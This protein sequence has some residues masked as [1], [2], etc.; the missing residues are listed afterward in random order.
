M[1]PASWISAQNLLAQ[2][3]GIALLAVQ[4][5][6]LGPR[7][8][9]LMA[10]VM[11]FIG[12]CDTVLQVAATDALISVREIEDEHYA[13]IMTVSAALATA[14]GIGVLIFAR[15]IALFFD[16]P[17]LEAMLRWM[18]LLPL[19]SVLASAPSAASRR[20]LNFRP[21][22]IRELAGMIV[23]GIFGMA[24]ALLHCG[25]WALVVQTIVQRVLN[26][27]ILWRLVAV[28]FRLG[29][30][31]AHFSELWRYA[32]PMMV[33]QMMSWSAAQIPRFFLGFYLGATD[34]GIFSLASRFNDIVVQT[35]V[36][37]PY[38]VARIQMREFIT[39]RSGFD[40]AVR[41]L[42]QRMAFLCFPLCIGGAVAMP[43]LIGAW[44]DP[45]WANG[46]VASQLMLLGAMPYVSHYGLSAVLLATNN[47]PQI[48][49]N[50]TFQSITTAAVVPIFGAL[51]LTAATAAIALRP[52]ASASIPLVMARR[53]CGI[54]T[55]L[56]LQAQ[57][58]VL[59]AAIIMGG[60]VWLL[61]SLLVSHI[62]GALLLP[63]LIAAGA[64]SYAVF[65]R[66]LA[67]D[68][69]RSYVSRFLG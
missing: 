26:V 5:P 49:V 16:E 66:Y 68:L 65:I 50:S 63:I 60:V 32:G 46:V 18:A 47:Q 41:R 64:L 23:G 30:S 12:F 35:T 44:L 42:L 55:K 33:S 40:S 31:A 6:L 4:A 3:I 53:H 11:V 15:G 62:G 8:F 51:G 28:R 69:A 14:I 13:T 61:R 39:E 17:K 27:T 52:L 57:A 48:A 67:P 24:L 10:L 21:L 43:V 34:L 45:R 56:V 22:V 2:I 9:G 1:S 19:V 38:M 29:F 20:E 58:R 7:A 59:G 25:V 37:P 54:S 36:V